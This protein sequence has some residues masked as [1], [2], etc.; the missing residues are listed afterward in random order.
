MAWPRRWP[1]RPGEGSTWRASCRWRARL[2]AIWPRRAC[3]GDRDAPH[4]GGRLV[5]GR[6][7]PGPVGSAYAAR[8]AG[9]AP[10][11]APLPVQYADYAIWQRERARRR[12]M[13]RTAWWRPSW[14]TGA[15][16]WPGCPA[17]LALPADRPRPAE[18]SHRGGAVEVQVDGDV[19]AGLVEVARA[20]RATLFMVVQAALA[21][22]LSRHGG[23]EDIPVGTS[24]AG[25][26][27]AALDEL[28]GFFLNTLVLRTDLSGDPT[29]RRAGEPGPRR[30]PGRLRPPG[31]PVRAA[32]RSAQP[33]SVTGQASA[34]PGHA[35][36]PD[37]PSRTRRNGSCPACG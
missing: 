26:G 25:R 2:L 17:E 30:R 15:R 4:R 9:Q 28:V 27:D 34:L 11:W 36:L 24:V 31:P 12:P 29:V 16:R 13:T 35:H 3:A 23:G 32:G 18:S 33:G 6:A 7:G 22:L 21:V 5:D 20:G 19:H 14:R 1:K 10:G 8:R 37:W